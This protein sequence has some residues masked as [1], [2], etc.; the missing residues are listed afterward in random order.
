MLLEVRIEDD[1]PL[2]EDDAVK[3]HQTGKR[4]SYIL[5]RVMNFKAAASPFTATHLKK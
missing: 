1:G 3:V 5:C 2:V 4:Q